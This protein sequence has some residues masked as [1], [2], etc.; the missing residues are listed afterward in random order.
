MLELA[1][2]HACCIERDVEDI[3]LVATEEK[4]RLQLCWS[5]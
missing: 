3:D 4:G 1:S 5:A 2:I